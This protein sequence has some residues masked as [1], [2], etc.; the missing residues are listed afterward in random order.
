MLLLYLAAEKQNNWNWNRLFSVSFCKFLDRHGSVLHDWVLRTKVYFLDCESKFQL[1]Y[2]CWC[3]N[4]CSCV[5]TWANVC[6]NVD[7]EFLNYCYQLL[8]DKELIVPQCQKHL[9]NTHC[10]CFYCDKRKFYDKR[11]TYKYIFVVKIT[12]AIISIGDNIP[13]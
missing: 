7:Y 6:R 11:N 13:K 8:R 1:F 5:P 9:K 3:S 4:S 12:L 2:S 10:Y